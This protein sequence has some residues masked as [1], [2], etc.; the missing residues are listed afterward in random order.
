[1]IKIIYLLFV[2]FCLLISYHCLFASVYY[3]NLEN[4]P[5]AI[6][7][8]LYHSST[9]CISGEDH[10]LLTFIKKCKDNHVDFY[11]SSFKSVDDA[12]YAT[13]RE[14][15]NK[16]AV[17]LKSISFD[18]AIAKLWIAYNQDVLGPEEFMKKELYF[19]FLS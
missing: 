14:L 7:H 19:E 12:L 5:K 16:G 3:I 9:A 1:M 17:P 10:S 6:V 15:I 11:L 2:F 13:S 18:A 4:G 8:H